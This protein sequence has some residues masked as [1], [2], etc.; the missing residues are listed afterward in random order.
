MRL[1]SLHPELLDQN[2]LGGQWKEALEAQAILMGEKRKHSNHPQ[3]IR[4]K[5]HHCPNKAI[6]FYLWWIYCEA[7]DR[8]YNYNRKLIIE[9]AFTFCPTIPVTK[10]QLEYEWKL[11]KHKFTTRKNLKLSPYLQNK[12]LEKVKPF[13]HPI[14]K[15][16]DGEIEEW[17]R[18]KEWGN[19]KENV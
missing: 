6:E 1:W 3:L 7:D 15:I 17:E 13:C 9:S 19:V 8:L 12:D 2:G 18:V 16:I 14:F 10:G 4:F 5:K 11:L